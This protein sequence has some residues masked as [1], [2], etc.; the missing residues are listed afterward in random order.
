[1]QNS[2]YFADQDKM[3]VLGK[4]SVMSVCGESGDASQFSEYIQKNLQ[5]YKMRNGY[6]I[7]TSGMAHFTRKA[8]ADALRQAVC[9][10]CVDTN[11]VKVH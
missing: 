2:F 5:L 3:M 1:M 6:E 7:S 10:S 4:N 11:I 8:L 9:Q